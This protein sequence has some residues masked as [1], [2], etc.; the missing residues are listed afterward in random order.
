MKRLKIVLCFM[1]VFCMGIIFVGCDK[2]EVK[3]PSNPNAPTRESLIADITKDREASLQLSEIDYGKVTIDKNFDFDGISNYVRIDV[4]NYGSITLLL[5]P[6]V[7]PKTV[8]NFKKLALEG[9]YDGL[10]FHRAIKGLMIEGGE[11]DTDHVIHDSDM[12]YGE[13]ADNNFTNNLPH[14]KGVIS[15]SRK[16]IPDSAMGSFFIVCGDAPQL[17]SRYAAFG[18]VIEGMDIVEKIENAEVGSNDAPTT[19]I[20][21]EK[22]VFLETAEIGE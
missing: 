13:F 17:D 18:Y 1:L 10:I 9:F 4:E 20:V 15:M 2:S 14:I 6:D 5:R 8:N 12:I 22:V 21:I 11:Q 16:N 19:A 3:L 7:A